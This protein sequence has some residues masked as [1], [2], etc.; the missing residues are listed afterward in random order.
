[1]LFFIDAADVLLKYH[2][3]ITKM[4][5]YN[6]ASHA[7]DTSLASVPLSPKNFSLMAFQI[8]LD[9]IGVDI[10]AVTKAELLVNFVEQSQFK[11]HMEIYAV[12]SYDYNAKYI[13][14]CRFKFMNDDVKAGPIYWEDINLSS[15]N[16]MTPP[17]LASILNPFLKDKEDIWTRK[18]FIIL[19]F[20][21]EK[22]TEIKISN[23]E[24]VLTYVDRTPGK[25]MD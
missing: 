4:A 24:I 12:R 21:M 7:C 2:A 13:E 25:R 20:F 23:V 17:D 18:V 11:G 16:K 19:K 3:N 1:M 9:A 8:D 14:Q 6:A 10:E 5:F 22:S 15:A